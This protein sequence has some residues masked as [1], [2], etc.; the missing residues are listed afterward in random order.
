MQFQILSHASLVVRSRSKT[1][2]I[3]P[4]LIGSCYWR[5]WWNYPPVNPDLLQNLT[6]DAIYITHIHWDHFHGPSLRKFSKRTPILIP[7]ERSTRISRDLRDMGFTNIVEIP[8][9]KSFDLDK[10]FRITSYHFSPWGDSAV[11]IEAEG[12]SL[13]DANDAK[14]I[15]RPLDQIIR[16]HR[17]FDFAF[18]SH[19]SAN[20]RICYF[21]R[22]RAAP[23]LEDPILYAQSFF[24]FM[25]KVKPTYAVP[26][27]SNHCFLHKDV[28]HLNAIIETP[29]RV[30][31][32][33]ASVGG[34]LDTTLKIMVS[35]DA[36]DSTSGFH[37]QEHTWFVDRDKHIQDYRTTQAE[38]LNA[39]YAQEDSARVRFAEFQRYF[40]RF[41]EVVPRSLKR[42]FK[43]KRIV[44]CAKYGSG[45]DYFQIDMHGNNISQ[46]AK[47]S[48]TE[49]SIV[50]ETT[51]LVMKQAMAL[52]M[53]SHIGISKRVR[54]LSR[55]ADS[56]Y[57]SYFNTLL[58]AYEYEVLPLQRLFS[59]RTIKAY[60]RRW[61]ELLLYC[62]IAAGLLTGKSIRE[63]ETDHL[64]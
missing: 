5:S 3:D 26:F 47:E 17:R 16:N 48:L 34:F 60:A 13:L 61:R 27:A 40:R 45:A 38:K 41:L 62:Q 6:P 2:L 14:F 21:Y 36:W 18:R 59:S 50:F 10:D 54:Y 52:N 56:K 23:K 46:I 19:S 33:V 55:Y 58:A 4:W 15:G 53:F 30:Q 42:P 39:T 11:V 57:M 22:D 9:G 44:F 64:R 24:S 35:G 63:L 8:H 20:D 29:I 28:F 51:A 12:V 25:Q 31:D 37:L 43:G 32:Y 7:L 1:A 49:E